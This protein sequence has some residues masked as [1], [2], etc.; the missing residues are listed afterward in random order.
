MR[1]IW[2]FEPERMPSAMAPLHD[3]VEVQAIDTSPR[4]GSAM[5][6]AGLAVLLVAV[7]LAAVAQLVPIPFN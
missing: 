1:I 6:L 3:A 2:N 7:A 5:S 4:K